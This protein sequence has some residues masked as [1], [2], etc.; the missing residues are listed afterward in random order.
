MLDK[1]LLLSKAK[2]E[3]ISALVIYSGPGLFTSLRIGFAFV[4]A[5]Y[6]KKRDYKLYTI[7]S[8]DALA[9]LSHE[10]KYIPC[11]PAQ[12]NEVF[13]AIYEKG[14]RI[15]DYSIGKEKEIFEKYQGY[16]IEILDEF[17]DAETLFK[18]FNNLKN[19][20]SPQDPVATEPFYIRLPDAYSKLKAT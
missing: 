6:L 11:L 10:A 5:F 13:Y 9:S 12:K 16:K 3:E 4:K 18:A 17:P 1:I 20:L 2:V 14:Q 7:N 19:T 15:S 8:L